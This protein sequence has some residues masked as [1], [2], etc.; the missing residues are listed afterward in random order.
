MFPGV[1]RKGGTGLEGRLYGISRSY[2][3]ESIPSGGSRVRG[4]GVGGLGF[5]GSGLV[6]GVEGSRIGCYVSG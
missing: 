3:R 2:Y 5:Q 1:S 4:L 6:F